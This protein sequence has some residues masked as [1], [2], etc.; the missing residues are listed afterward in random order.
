M[1]ANEE[2]KPRWTSLLGAAREDILEAAAAEREWAERLPERVIEHLRALRGLQHVEAMP[3][4]RLEHSLQ[5]ATRA[6]RDNRSEDYVVCALLH[7][8]GDVLMPSAH[9]EIAACI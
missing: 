9:A 7:D 1:M 4:D 6:Y 2:H 5:C 3:V 8:I